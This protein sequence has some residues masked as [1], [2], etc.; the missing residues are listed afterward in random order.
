MI[1]ATLASLI[2]GC[3]AAF[4]ALLAIDPSFLDNLTSP[5]DILLLLVFIISFSFP[6]TL[7]IGVATGIVFYRLAMNHQSW[8]RARL[9]R[10]G[11][12]FGALVG[13]LPMLGALAVR[14]D[15]FPLSRVV[16]IG[17]ITGG[18]CGAVLGWYSGRVLRFE[19]GPSRGNRRR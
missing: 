8:S 1:A 19:P 9:T 7:T 13:A 5:E 2:G 4:A 17:V 14:D 12:I 16:G 15:S 3:V 6:I 18:I 11:S 10:V